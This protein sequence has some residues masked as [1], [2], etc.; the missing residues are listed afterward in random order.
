MTHDVERS[1]RAPDEM[2]RLHALI[3]ANDWD[4]SVEIAKGLDDELKPQVR[5][6]FLTQWKEGGAQQLDSIW[7]EERE[8]RQVA[9]FAAIKAKHDAK[10]AAERARVKALR[11]AVEPEVKPEAKPETKVL[12]FLD[13]KPATTQPAQSAQPAQPIPSGGWRDAPTAPPNATPEERLLYPP[14]LIGHVVQ[15]IIDVDLFPDRRMALWAALASCAKA[16]DRKVIGPTGSSTL[17]YLILLAATSAGKQN[18]HDSIP[19]LLRAM[20]IENLLQ[21]GGLASV[22]ATEDL[23]R[24]SP[25]CFVLIDEFGRWLRMVLDQT[26]NVRELPGTLCKFWGIRP[27]GSWRITRRARE[28]VDSVTIDWPALALAGCTFGAIFWDACGDEEITG[29]FLNRCVIF[30]AGK[31]G[32]RAKPK[33]S[34]EELPIWLAAALKERAGI[35]ASNGPTVITKT[36]GLLGPRRLTWG[37]GA[38]E[39]WEREVDTIRDLDE[40]RRRDIF[41]R[42][43][44]IAVRLATVVAWWRGSEVV[45][46]GDWEWGWAWAKLSCDL[47]LKGANERMKVKREFDKI[48]AHIKSLLAD[49][50][51][52]IGDI[53]LHSRS[54]AGDRGMEIVDKALDDLVLSEEI[55]ELSTAEQEELGLKPKGA[56]RR[57]R[58][59]QLA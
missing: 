10:V 17:L 5:E 58:W 14:G 40:G 12:S 45:E 19:I 2:S 52:K 15:H 39:L 49:G 56:G 33:Y 24:G 46:V 22:Q 38:E 21:A 51:R 4:G 54:A 8:R 41:A 31:G 47:I 28:Q 6:W 43:P 48:C 37:I 20:G 13:R 26:S 25:N 34:W 29:G 3:N 35:P 23:I 11:E 42:A 9:T 1:N 53:H 32:K 36:Q 18:S 30:D 44:E 16:L 50:P 7:E 59:F 55:E 57:T 27:G